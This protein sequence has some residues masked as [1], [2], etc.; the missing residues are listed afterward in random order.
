ML[1]PPP[2]AANFARALGDCRSGVAF[3]EFAFALPVV[4]FID[5]WHRAPNEAVGFVHA[6]G[7]RGGT[8]ALKLVLA[9]RSEG[10]RTYPDSAA[11]VELAPLAAAHQ[12]ELL[13]QLLGEPAEAQAVIDWLGEHANGL[14]FD[15]AEIAL[16][17]RR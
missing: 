5:D 15:L 12:L 7:R 17:L 3:L 9:A 1:K 6:C 8:S 2:L 10:E 13:E 11:I 4:L 16:S 14:P